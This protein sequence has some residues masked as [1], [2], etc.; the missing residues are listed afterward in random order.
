[1]M[2]RAARAGGWGARGSVEPL[3]GTSAAALAGKL[4][5]TPSAAEAPPASVRRRVLG[6][7]EAAGIERHRTDEAAAPVLPCGPARAAQSEVFRVRRCGSWRRRALAV[8][9]T[10]HHNGLQDPERS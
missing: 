9:R 6:R 10:C 2:A 4:I 1:M 3:P 7:R 5:V 8:P